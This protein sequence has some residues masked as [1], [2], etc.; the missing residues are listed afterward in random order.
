MDKQ[1]EMYIFI[2]I[3]AFFLL[4]M[5]TNSQKVTAQSSL[6]AAQISAGQ[7]N[8]YANDAAS[9]INTALNNFSD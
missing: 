8:T 5:L 3:G 1:T 4:S 6:A 2:G 9:V 7:T